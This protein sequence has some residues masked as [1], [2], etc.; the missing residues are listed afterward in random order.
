MAKKIEML[1]KVFGDWKVI[2]ELPERGADR[3]I[4]W[5]VQCQNCG[6]IEKKNGSNLRSGHSSKC[7]KCSNKKSAWDRAIKDLR[8]QTFGLL[9]VIDYTDERASGG[10]VIWLCQCECGNIKKIGANSL[11]T[12][13]MSC[14]CLNSRGEAKI[15]R[16]LLDNH[17]PFEV[18]K[19]F[20]D[21]I[22][23]QTN[24]NLIFDFF[25]DNKYIIEYDGEQHFQ[26]SKSG[27]WGSKIV[28]Q[29]VQFR[30]NIKN[31]YCFNNNIPI[32]RIP[33]THF[34]DLQIEDLML[35]TSKFILKKE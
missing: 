27:G 5:E 34:N 1:G 12:G 16:L 15:I 21:C 25:V 35:S 8:G 11:K 14:G 23:P 32:I 4:M 33:Y 6:R 24:N 19:K 29:E 7:I 9:T 20:E 26:Q 30:D 31:Q 3:S 17:I 18:Q 2:N 28:L 10:S 13:T 22:N